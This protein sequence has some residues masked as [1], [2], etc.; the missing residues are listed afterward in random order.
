MAAYFRGDTELDAAVGFTRGT[1][2]K[3]E[4]AGAVARRL[5]KT[6]LLVD[7]AATVRVAEVE[8]REEAVY[9]R[10]AG[11]PAEEDPSLRVRQGEEDDQEKYLDCAVKDDEISIHH[12]LPETNCRDERENNSTVETVDNGILVE[13]FR[14]GHAGVARWLHVPEHGSDNYNIGGDSDSKA[15]P[16]EDFNAISHNLE[17]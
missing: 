16:T 13:A 7:A 10:L 4:R 2:G 11:H 9:I 3:T 12:F 17:E 15:D 8:H 5:V 1:H 14:L 6:I